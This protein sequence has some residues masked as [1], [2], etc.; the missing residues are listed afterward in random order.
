MDDYIKIDQ[1]YYFDELS[2]ILQSVTTNFTSFNSKK[3]TEK[4]SKPF[5]T[6]ECLKMVV[7][8]KKG[9]SLYRKFPSA[10]KRNAFNVEAAKTKSF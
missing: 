9:R 10:E 2:S 5:W 4:F 7:L 6:A 1:I 8:R 3:C